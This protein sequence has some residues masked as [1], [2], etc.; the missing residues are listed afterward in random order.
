VKYVI[1]IHSNPAPWGHPTS[2]FT[3]EGRALAAEQHEQMDA[4]FDALLDELS[5]N[6]ELL[7]GE[8]LAA[9]MTSTV[10]RWSP[11]GRVATDGPYAESKEA[12]AGFFVI[13]VATPERA[14]QVALAFAGPG[15][16]AELRPAMRAG[17]DDA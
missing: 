6:G 17:G 13:D 3:D 14:R 2:R 7:T 1:L 10:V 15:S 5:Q 12:L 9:P 16:V 8:A 11:E 4:E